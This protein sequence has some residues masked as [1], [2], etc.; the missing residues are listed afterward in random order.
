MTARTGDPSLRE[1]PAKAEE[2]KEDQRVLFSKGMRSGP[3][4]GKLKFSSKFLSLL[5][6]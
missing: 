1:Q 6:V 3:E 2:E 5:M 4:D